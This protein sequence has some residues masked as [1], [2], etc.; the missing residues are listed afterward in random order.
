MGAFNKT[1]HNI[2]KRRTVNLIGG[3][4]KG[5]KLT[6]WK[7]GSIRPVM[8]LV[9]KSIFDTIGAFIYDVNVLDLCA[10]SG[11][12]GIEALSRGAS[13]LTLVDSDKSAIKIIYR[14]LSI[15]KLHANVL[16]G[17]LP[18]VLNKIDLRDGQY[19]LIFLD[20]PYGNEKLI[21]TVLGVLILNN[22]IAKDALISIETENKANF[23]MPS[24]LILYKEKK[25]GSTKITMLK[26]NTSNAN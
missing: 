20:P 2:S 14:N 24:K 25:F 18:K 16:Y 17:R 21:E 13:S 11:I 6:S 7:K 23:L 10:G 19:N 4:L 12:L 3:K 1:R 9:R 22:L 15:C 8:A 5:K 26:Y